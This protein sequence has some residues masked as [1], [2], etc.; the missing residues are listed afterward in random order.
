[1]Y[2]LE[3]SWVRLNHCQR[4]GKRVKELRIEREFTQEQLSERAGVFRTYMSRIETGVANP[5]LTMIHALADALEVSATALLEAPVRAKA[6]P[7]AK[8]KVRSPTGGSR[9][10]VK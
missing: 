1:V 2:I 7:R 8:E 4:F 5:T 10:R 6:S 9:G 3:H